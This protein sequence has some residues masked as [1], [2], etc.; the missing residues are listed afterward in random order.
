[1]SVS[2]SPEG[3]SPVYDVSSEK[4]TLSPTRR[5]PAG[6]RLL[7]IATS[8]PAVMFTV[9]EAVSLDETG[10]DGFWLITEAAAVMSEPLA[11]AT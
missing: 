5:L 10:S 11:A 9:P 4:V 8:V 1:M 2:D 3:A 6:E 7:L